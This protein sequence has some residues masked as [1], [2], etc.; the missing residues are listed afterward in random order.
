MN[1]TVE[2]FVVGASSFNTKS[3]AFLNTV[4]SGSLKFQWPSS[5]D[6]TATVTTNGGFLLIQA[7]TASMTFSFV[8]ASPKKLPLVGIPAGILLGYN[9][10]V[11]YTKVITP[12]V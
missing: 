1:S 12:R 7:T 5:S 4:P 3:T 6:N 11:I 2:Y 8:K 10:E 9:S